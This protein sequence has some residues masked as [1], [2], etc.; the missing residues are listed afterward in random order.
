MLSR[1]SRTAKSCSRRRSKKVEERLLTSRLY[2]PTPTKESSSWTPPSTSHAA[3]TR[4]PLVTCDGLPCVCPVYR[5]SPVS[6]VRKSNG[7]HTRTSGEGGTRGHR[8]RSFK[9]QTLYSGSS[10]AWLEHPLWERRVA[11]SNLVSPT[12]RIGT[13]SD[14]L[15]TKHARVAQGTERSA[16]DRQVEGSNP[17]SSAMQHILRSSVVEHRAVLGGRG[18]ES[19]RR[20]CRSLFS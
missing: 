5:G 1:S 13:S 2:S 3:S 18:F 19:L 17:S 6:Y 16:T 4:P 12:N 11:S 15:F 14:Q 10:S 7:P 8:P 20:V 9:P